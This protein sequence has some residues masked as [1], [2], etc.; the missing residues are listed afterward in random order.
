MKSQV[1]NSAVTLAVIFV[2]ES[3]QSF[4][5]SKILLSVN[6]S[7]LKNCNRKTSY[8]LP[9]CWDCEQSKLSST[10]P[11]L[12]IIQEPHRK[13]SDVLRQVFRL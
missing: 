4:P 5:V 2:N 3:G 6:W 9:K 8:P 13:K 10:L 7:Y 1:C 12:E 11:G